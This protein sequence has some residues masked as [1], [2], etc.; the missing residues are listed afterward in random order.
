MK[1]GP[2][3]PTSYTPQIGREICNRL[4]LG[5]SLRS[6]CRSGHIPDRQ[7]ITNW[8]TRDADFAASI[9]RAREMQA[10]DYHDRAVELAERVLSGEVD[11]HAAKV[12]LSAWQ[13]SASK[14]R[15]KNYGDRTALN[16][17][18]ESGGPVEVRWLSSPDER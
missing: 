10:D 16:V 14:L 5:E 2:G 11:A 17:S 3:R 1:R 7:T 6:I 9:A 18:G 4:A 13:W 15:P 8:A 12:A